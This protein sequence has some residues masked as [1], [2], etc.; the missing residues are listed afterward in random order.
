MTAEVKRNPDY[1]TERIKLPMPDLTL[2]HVD[3]SVSDN[4]DTFPENLHVGF[5]IYI[6]EEV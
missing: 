2:Q 3:E 4:K 5:G 1:T 6:T